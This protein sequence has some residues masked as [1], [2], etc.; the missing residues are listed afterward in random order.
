MKLTKKLLAAL[1]SLLVVFSLCAC[2]GN[3]DDDTTDAQNNNPTESTPIEDNSDDASSEEETAG[4]KVTVV[5]K[6]GKGIENVTVQLCK[7]SCRPGFTDANGVAV[8]DGEITDG[9]KLSVLVCPEGYEY[10]GEKEI[11]LESGI[12]EYTIELD[13]AA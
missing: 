12:T 6:N 13:E 8:F 11:Y 1:L 4:F 10:N 7:D 9:Y 2:G 5:D 3:S